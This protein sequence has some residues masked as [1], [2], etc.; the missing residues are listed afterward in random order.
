MLNLKASVG[1]LAKANS[2][3]TMMNRRNQNGSTEEVVSAINKLRKDL[4]NVGNTYTIGDITYDDG[5]S[6]SDAVQS[7]VRAARVERRT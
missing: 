6:I 5:S 1:T 7:L 2:I 3:S 4:G